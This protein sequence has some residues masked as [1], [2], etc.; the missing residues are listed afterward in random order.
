MRRHQRLD[1]FLVDLYLVDTVKAYE[2]LCRELTTSEGWRKWASAG[3]CQDFHLGD[4]SDGVPEHH[5]V[6]CID[7]RV[8]AHKSTGPHDQIR[9]IAHE[10]THAAGMILDRLGHQYDGVDEPLAY[11]VGH[12]TQWAWSELIGE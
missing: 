9:L 12:L 3:M 5:V 7:K 8:L 4:G 11:L 1:V 10:A 2:K 6:M